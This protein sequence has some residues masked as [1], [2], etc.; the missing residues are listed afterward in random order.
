M[1]RD[2]R[3][4]IMLT[5]AK[6]LDTLHKAGLVHGD[7]KPDNLLIKALDKG[8]F[9][10]KVI[11]FDNCF[12]VRNPP[13]ADQL[14]GDPTFY[15]PELLRYTVG[16]APGDHLDEKNDVFALGLVFWQ[17]LTGERPELPD[18]VN[19]PAE[20]VNQGS[21]AV[22]AQVGRGPAAR[23]SRAFDARQ[24][25]R[26]AAEHERR[27]QR[28]QDGAEARPRQARASP[29]SPR[30]AAHAARGVSSRHM[31]SRLR[32]PTGAPSHV[33]GRRRQPR[34]IAAPAQGL[35]QPPAARST[36]AGRAPG[37]PPADQPA[38]ALKGSLG[39]RRP[40]GGSPGAP[41]AAEEKDE[42]DKTGG[43]LRGTLLKKEKKEE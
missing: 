42:E 7:V 25:I 24:R 6:S 4:F 34:P 21:R 9:A 10:I 41:A 19:Y 5:A 36:V 1:D 40:A 20:A 22:P 8:R 37:D 32:G 27:A 26:R 38:P 13:A 15:S 17:Y 18:G 3:I 14:V 23:G 28:A 16:E 12:P 43:K 39:R 11:D 35:P 31:W 29:R 2:S 30:R 33:P